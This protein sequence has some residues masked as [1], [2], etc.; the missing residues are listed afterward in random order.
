M[1]KASMMKSRGIM[2]ILSP[3]KTLDLSPLTRPSLPPTTLPDCN[4][5]Q[6]AQV[7]QAMKERTE[8]E[9]KSLL[10]ISAALAKTSREYWERFDVASPP[11]EENTKPSIFSF[12]GAAYQGL[13]IQQR[14][15]KALKYLQINLRIIDPVYG[16]LRP[17]DMMQPYRLEMATKK[18][19]AHDTSIKLADYWK[20]SVTESLSADL[21]TRSLPILLNLASDEYA[22]AVDDTALPGQFV[23]VVF[24]D[25]GRVVAVHAKRAR[26]LMCKFMSENDVESLE[27]VQRFNEEGYAFDESTSNKQ[28]LVFE[29]AVAPLPM[30]KRATTSGTTEQ[31]KAGTSVKRTRKK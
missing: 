6:T 8:S 2:M 3:A 31:I 30:K 22:A 25:Q 15:D 11:T 10:G 12:S 28:A 27:D 19:L 29:R 14:S 4:P 21:K 23:K 20:E 16:V 5:K 24:K 18:A 9:L 17:L 26:G 7:A 13:D 1:T